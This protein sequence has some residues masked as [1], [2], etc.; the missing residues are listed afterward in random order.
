MKRG[1]KVAPRC[2]P[3]TTP[4]GV[5]EDSPMKR[6]LKVP[7]AGAGAAKLDVEEDSPMKRGLKGQIG[8]AGRCGHGC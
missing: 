5:E 2:C 7:V 8:E 3:L 6:G 1:L 4:G